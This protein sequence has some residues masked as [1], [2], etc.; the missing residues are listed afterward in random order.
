[1]KKVLLFLLVAVPLFAQQ[2]QSSTAPLFAVNAKY[3]NGVAPGYAPTAGSGLTLNL[4]KGTANC[5]GTLVEYA[6]GTLT[7]TNTATNYVYLAP[8]SSCAPTSNTSSFT[9]TTVWVA[10]VTTSGGAI[11]AIDDVRTGFLAPGTGAGSVTSIATTS[12]ITGGTI[13]S[14]G[15]LGCATCV[16][17]A[18]S[19]T[20][21]DIM[22]G[23]GSQASQTPSNNATVDSS[24]NMTAAQL[25]VT[26]IIDGES[27]IT[28][29]TGSTATLGGTYNS[30]YTFNQEATAAT[31]VIYTLPTAAAGKQFCIK[32]SYNGSAA[33]TGALRFSTSASGQYIIYSGVLSA[34]NGYIISGGAAGDSACVVGIDATH[35][36]AYA[37]VGTWTLH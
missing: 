20:S 12:P 16:T 33:D 10:K 32:N 11:T 21:T 19:L 34:T 3:A 17:A 29:T 7:M 25:L 23:A 18:S 14:T 9:S 35:W 36:E 6:G 26:G 2:P 37:Q 22:T 5:L 31:A 28:L 15:T 8:S 27:P 1:M 30:G 4:G 24:G 13:T